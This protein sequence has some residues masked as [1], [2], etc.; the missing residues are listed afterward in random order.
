VIGIADGSTSD[1]VLIKMAQ[2]GDEV[3]R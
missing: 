1:E 3:F 2:F